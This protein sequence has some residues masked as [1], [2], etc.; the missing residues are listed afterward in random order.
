MAVL[1]ACMP[2]SRCCRVLEHS[3][4]CSKLLVLAVGAWLRGSC[5]AGRACWDLWRPQSPTPFLLQLVP[6]SR[7]HRKASIGNLQRRHL[8]LSV[9]LTVKNKTSSLFCSYGISHVPV[10]APCP[11]FY[12]CMPQRSLPPP[13]N[14]YK[15]Q[16]DSLSAFSRL[17]S[18]SSLSLSS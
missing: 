2:Y 3:S 6:Y 13:L 14:I 4:P 1:S 15:Q 12:S 8:N 10:S 18:P 7:S 16:C 11:L 5:R 17:K 9:T